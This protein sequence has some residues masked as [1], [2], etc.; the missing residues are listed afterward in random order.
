MSSRNTIRLTI[1]MTAL[2]PLLATA[3]PHHG[4][5]ELHPVA[6]LRHLEQGQL[7]GLL[8]GAGMGQAK[9]AE[10]NGYP[11]P[12]HAIELSREL[13]LTPAQVDQLRDLKTET[14]AR[15]MALGR[16]VVEEE[17][18]LQQVFAAGRIDT[19]KLDQVVTRISMLRGQVRFIHL[20]AH[21]RAAELMTAQQVEKYQALRR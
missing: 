12:K 9:A 15:A 1:F 5:G 14:I 4:E 13:A 11:G 18:L 6:D 8:S 19:G 2:I 10:L 3:Q 7:Q 20:S 17:K 21:L 16:Q